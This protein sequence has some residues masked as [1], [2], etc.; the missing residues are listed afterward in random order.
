MNLTTTEYKV[1][2]T[3]LNKC[4]NKVSYWIWTTKYCE[5]N[6]HKKWNIKTFKK[7]SDAGIFVNNICCRTNSCRRWKGFANCGRWRGWWGRIKTHPMRLRRTSAGNTHHS[8]MVTRNQTSSWL[9]LKLWLKQAFAWKVIFRC[10]FVVIDQLKSTKAI[11]DQ[12]SASIASLTNPTIV[13][14]T[15][16]SWLRQ[17]IQ[18]GDLCNILEP[19]F[20]LVLNPRTHRKQY[21]AAS[22][23]AAMGNCQLVDFMEHEFFANNN[24]FLLHFVNMVVDIYHH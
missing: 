10:L 24:Y 13:M 4:C 1:Q 8:L 16:S 15:V 18:E 6:V 12:S 22:K 5:S 20:L 9:Q 14:R 23:Q 3:N 2:I 17:C 19:Y 7:M 11:T 21:H